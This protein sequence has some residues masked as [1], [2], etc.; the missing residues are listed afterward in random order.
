MN[1]HEKIE[2][3]SYY[4]RLQNILGNIPTETDKM[5]NEELKSYTE[6]QELAK[7]L[8]VAFFI[9]KVMA[10]AYPKGIM[11]NRERKVNRL[12]EWISEDAKLPTIKEAV[13]FAKNM[14]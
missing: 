11:S 9:D 5:N 10:R 2:R 3:K 13:S 7:D 12:R 6:D 1:A 14:R 8:E 4:Q